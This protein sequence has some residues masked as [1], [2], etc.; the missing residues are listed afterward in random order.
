MMVKLVVCL[1][2][3]WCKTTPALYGL[4]Y[5]FNGYKMKAP[6]QVSHCFLKG[7]VF[8]QQ[9]NLTAHFK[10][11]GHQDYETTFTTLRSTDA[12]GNDE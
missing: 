11:L 1:L 12:H 5:H 3:G 7:A 6:P 4:F 10:P 2:G 8:I 9:P